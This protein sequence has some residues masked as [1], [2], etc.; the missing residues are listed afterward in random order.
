MYVHINVLMVMCVYM[1]PSCMCMFV[2]ICMS[3]C[4]YRYG[5][6]CFVYVCMNVHVCVL[7]SHKDLTNTVP[8]NLYLHKMYKRTDNNPVSL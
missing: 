4:M 8:L 3:I 2:C 5:A 7:Y 6:Y 1:Y